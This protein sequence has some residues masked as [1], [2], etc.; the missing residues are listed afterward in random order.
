MNK[1][2]LPLII[3][4]VIII[5]TSGCLSSL[6]GDYKIQVK[7]EVKP[8]TSSV[9]LKLSDKK[10]LIVLNITMPKTGEITIKPYND[11]ITIENYTV[12]TLNDKMNI[13]IKIPS[14]DYIT[15]KLSLKNRVEVARLIMGNKT[16]VLILTYTH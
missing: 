4:V 16:S 12:K 8:I 3:I 13:L 1:K 9:S 7:G 10:L 15:N 14:S 11:N 2:A 5:L 6:H